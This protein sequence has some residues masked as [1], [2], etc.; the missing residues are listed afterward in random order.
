MGYEKR[1]VMSQVFGLLGLVF[2]LFLLVGAVFSGVGGFSW[3]S[4]QR[5]QADGVDAMGTVETR[6]ESKRPCKDRNSGITRT[7]TDFNL[8]YSYQVAGQTLHHSATTSYDTYANLTEGARIK[9]RYLP[10]DPN[11]SVTSF[12]AEVVDASGGLRVMALIFG[13]LGVVFL[14]IGVGGLVWL[15]RRAMTAERLRDSGTARGAVVLAQEETNVRVNGQ[16]QRR[17]RWK[18]DSGALGASRRQ[19]GEN[20]PAVGDRITVYADPDGHRPAVWEGDCGS[21]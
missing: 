19:P 13:G 21:R 4:A 10:S 3:Q 2:G 9:L 6:W 7:C 5:F 15:I 18:D 17:I 1:S 8:G 16:A 12:G 20:L 14:A 11:N